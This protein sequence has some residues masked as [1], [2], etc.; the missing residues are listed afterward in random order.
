MICNVAFSNGLTFDAAFD[1]GNAARVE[2]AGEDEYHLWTAPDCHGTEHEKQYKAW[3][4]FAVGGA[5]RGRMLTFVMHNMN[6]LGKLFRHDMRPVYRYL[7]SKPRWSRIPIGTTQT[8]T[9][10]GD[11]NFTLSFKH[12]VECDPAVDT[13]QF[14]FCFPLTYTDT[15]ARLAFLDALFGASV[16]AAVL[17]PGVAAITPS[18]VSNDSAAKPMA[19][20]MAPASTAGA[21]ATAPAPAASEAAPAPAPPLPP[22]VEPSLLP[23]SGRAATA[24]ISSPGQRALTSKLPRPN[25]PPTALAAAPASAATSKLPKP[26]AATVADLLRTSPAATA[27]MPS[28]AKAPAPALT[29]TTATAPATATAAAAAAT[30]SAVAPANAPPLRDKGRLRSAVAALPATKGASA[31]ASVRPVATPP[32]A[33]AEASPTVADAVRAAPPGA[34]AAALAAALGADRAACLS[35]SRAVC[36]CPCMYMPIHNTYT[37]LGG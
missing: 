26:K 28:T 2:Q 18:T 25:V 34:H 35:A 11:A 6:N 31:T 36:I 19:K 8:G 3:F 27:A 13:M 20:P 29:P 4:A 24:S 21:P 32:H 1:G 30:T 15:I 14:A 23:R 17:P 16:P 37:C 33:P 22:S 7:P 9:N 5:E 10:K 12:R